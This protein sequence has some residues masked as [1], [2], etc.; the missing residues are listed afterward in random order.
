[1]NAF[2]AADRTLELGT[3]ARIVNVVN[4]THVMIPHQRPIPSNRILDLSDA[5]AKALG[6][7]QTG[8]SAIQLEVVTT[9]FS[10][11]EGLHLRSG[12]PQAR[13]LFDGALGSVSRPSLYVS[14]NNHIH[15][16]LAGTDVH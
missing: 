6:M 12:I 8:V 4:G 7:V 9:T 13:E 10:R 15:H 1:M 16:P 2:T 5:A 11:P 14:C 3:V